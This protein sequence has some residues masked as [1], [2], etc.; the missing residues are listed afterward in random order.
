MEQIAHNIN[1]DASSSKMI[2]SKPNSCKFIVVFLESVKSKITITLE[3]YCLK[4]EIKMKLK[5]WAADYDVA[6]GMKNVD[7][8]LTTNVDSRQVNKLH[9]KNALTTNDTD[10]QAKHLH[11]RAIKI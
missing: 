3:G 9:I 6:T 1:I 8:I 2:T 11:S 10:I 4:V 7:I 5:H